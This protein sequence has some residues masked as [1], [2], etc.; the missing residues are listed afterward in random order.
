M[1]DMTKPKTNK[2]N[3]ECMLASGLEIAELPV[4]C[5]TPG[6]LGSYEYPAV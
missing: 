1:V 2:Q 6:V 4:N 5:D 3:S